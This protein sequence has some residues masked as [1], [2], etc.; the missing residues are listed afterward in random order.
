MRNKAEAVD[1]SEEGEVV[2]SERLSR[3]SLF[4]SLCSDRFALRALEL[5]LDAA[6]Q[7]SMYE[8]EGHE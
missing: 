6:W 3:S 5:L 7:P 1:E 8:L 2:A 4:R